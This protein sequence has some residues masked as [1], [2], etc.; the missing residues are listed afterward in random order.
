MTDQEL[1]A[2]S[3]LAIIGRK[4]Q[5]GFGATGMTAVKDF[6]RLEAAGLY[7]PEAG[8][9]RRDVVIALGS[10][11]LTII[12]HRNVALA[13][14]SLAAVERIN[15]GRSPAIYAPDPGAEER[16]ETSEDTLIRAIEK[17][18]S[19]VDRS[20]PHPGRLRSRLTMAFCVAVFALAVFWLPGALVRYTARILPEATRT[21]IGTDLLDQVGRIS[22]NPCED[23]AGA[24]ALRTLAGKLAPPGSVQVEVVP[25]GVTDAAHLPGGIVLLGRSVVEDYETPDVVAGY[26]LA[27]TERARQTDPL[28][29]LLRHSGLRATLTL[30]TTGALPTGALD[31]YAETLMSRKPDPVSARALL[32][33]FEDAGISA[34]PY[35]YAVDITGEK[36]LALIEASPLPESEAKILLTDAEWV[37]LQSVCGA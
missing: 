2:A 26:I 27:E 35:A 21:A 22:G 10:A 33:Q 23:P 17:V 13:H 30:M 25:S 29:A 6:Q 15:P 9:Q 36:T 5:G 7:L 28:I 32:P 37:S 16:L 1:W 8:A 3:G 18:R 14:W 12:D 19:A 24:A 34:S 20:R 4:K 31:G 11:T